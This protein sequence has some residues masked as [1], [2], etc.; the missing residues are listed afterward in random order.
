MWKNLEM[1]CKNGKLTER[2]SNLLGSGYFENRERGRRREL[3]RKLKNVLNEDGELTY[4]MRTLTKSGHLE[5]RE[6]DRM[7]A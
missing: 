3:S 4:V 1:R 7:I 2:G 6:T 5:D